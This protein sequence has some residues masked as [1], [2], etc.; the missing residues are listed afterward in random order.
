MTTKIT[1]KTNDP[2]KF[3]AI[4]INDAHF[5]ANSPP[6]FKVD[7]LQLLEN[8]VKQVLAKASQLKVD[9]VIWSGDIFHLKEA[10]NN[11]L[12]LIAKVIGLMTD[13]GLTHLAIAGNHDIKFG[14][15]DTGLY[16]S[17]MDILIQS[18]M[19]SL[20]DRE[21]HYFELG[22]GYTVKIA[23]GSYEHSQAA[24]VRNKTKDGADL[25]INTGHF[26]LGTQTGEFFGEPL[27]GHD[28]FKDCETDVLIV[29]HHHDDKGVQLAFG[30][31]FVAPG[32]ICITGAHPHDLQRRPAASLIEAN[33][34][35]RDIH[36][37]RPKM[38]K[39]ED[40]LDL[41]RHAAIKQE[42][43][44]IDEFIETLANTEITTPDPEDILRQLNPVA[45]V[46]ERAL[47][48]IQEAETVK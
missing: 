38:P 2:K 6:A 20:L 46:R 11:P 29:G 7:Y 41:E 14:S 36:V 33:R 1:H 32:S 12:W 35:G 39:T 17:P 5:A 37:L 23:G 15:I 21:E 19:V 10:K 13:H 24:H 3:R 26:W 22:D 34:E 18:G 4:A 42:K 48:Y 45:E 30:K 44:E 43:K 9:A 16:G 47:L 28:Y 31:H 8:N 27:F 25:L 40:I